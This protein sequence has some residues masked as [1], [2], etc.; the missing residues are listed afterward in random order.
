MMIPRLVIASVL[1]IGGRFSS[2]TVGMRVSIRRSTMPTW[3][4]WQKQLTRKRPTPETPIAK[5]HSWVFSNSSRC[6]GVITFSTRSRDCCGVSGAWVIGLILPCTFIDGGMPAV[7]NR[8]DAFWCAISLRNEVKSMLLI[9]VAPGCGGCCIPPSPARGMA[10]PD[11]L[12]Q[13]LVL[14]VLARLLA[15]DHAAL[16][17]FLQV[18][19]EGLHAHV[20]AGLD[21]GIHLRHLVLADQVADRR[22]ADHDFPGRG[23]AA[24]DLLQ[25]RLRDHRAQ[26]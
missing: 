6:C 21:G 15:A 24:A 18:L 9:G 8:S 12:E 25:Q 16:D 13:P 11:S 10:V 3:L 26:R 22:G 23:A 7:M 2:S 1:M 14:G 4:R 19:V 17:Q 5:L 20:L